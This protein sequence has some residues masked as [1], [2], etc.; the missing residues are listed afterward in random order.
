MSEPED[1]IHDYAQDVLSEM[2]GD[3]AFQEMVDD[4]IR[5]DHGLHPLDRI[6][7]SAE[8]SA[9]YRLWY[10]TAA[11]IATKVLAQA[12]VQVRHFPDQPINTN[13]EE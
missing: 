10:E 13:S 4:I 5:G 9:E 7:D 3:D 6:D 11:S 8:N 12:I 1:R 2:L